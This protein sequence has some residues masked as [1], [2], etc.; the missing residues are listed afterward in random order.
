MPID[1]IQCINKCNFDHNNKFEI[2]N[3]C[4][5]INPIFINRIYYCDIL[6]SEK[7]IFKKINNQDFNIFFNIDDI[8]YLSYILTNNAK[9]EEIYSYNKILEKIEESLTS[10][11]Y[12]TSD[13][14]EGEEQCIKFN[15]MKISF[16]T[17]EKK[18]TNINKNI[19]ELVL[20]K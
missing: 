16:S 8:I 19:T 12:N 20:N 1:K 5:A 14:D 2:N 9:Q 17:T 4:Y 18:K 13:L 15:K 6:C 11:N 3:I 7:N 10:K